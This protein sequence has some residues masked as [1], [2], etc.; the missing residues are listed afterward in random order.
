IKWVYKNGE[1]SSDYFSV[2]YVDAVNHKRNF[3]PDFI[4]C[5]K[6]NKI[7]IIETKGGENA[8]GNSKNIDIKSENKFEGL[9]EY[10]KMYNVNWGFVRDYDKNDSLYL[11]NTEYTKDM[12]NDNWKL[13]KDFF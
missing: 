5:D 13:L 12:G 1:S 2:V 4:V 9:K 3:Y 10:A 11:C 7:W 8:S 6:N